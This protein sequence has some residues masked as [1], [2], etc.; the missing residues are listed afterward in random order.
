MLIY[1]GAPLTAFLVSVALQVFGD[2]LATAHLIFA[3]AIMP[4]IF[5]AITHFI[6]VLTRS[7]GPHR[8]VLLMP[9]MSLSCR[10]SGLPTSRGSAPW[11]GAAGLL[12]GVAS[13]FPSG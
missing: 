9:L 3:V 7:G 4:L 13:D 6:P 2:I 11:H 1:L 10:C 8:A 12:C 5:G